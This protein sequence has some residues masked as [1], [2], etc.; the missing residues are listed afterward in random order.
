MAPESKYILGVDGGATKTTAIIA[1]LKGNVLSEYMTGSSNC[2][3]IGLGKSIK[4]I[5][6]AV[7]GALRKLD[8]IDHYRIVSSCFGM[9]GNDTGKDMEIYREIILNE[10]LAP[11]L[12]VSGV[13]LCNDTRIGLAAGS[14]NKNRIMVIAGTGA[15]CYG[16]NE[17]GREASSDGW[18]Y[19]LG[20][21]GS[22]Y[23]IAIKALRAVMKA[24]DGRGE[25]TKLSTMVLK[26]L[27]L[28]SEPD[29]VEWAYGKKTG[30]EDISSIAKVVCDA[31]E[32]GDKLSIR[33]LKEA[34]EEVLLS[35]SA[36][37]NKLA[38]ADKSF[39]LVLVGGL[40]KCREYFK[41][42]FVRALKDKYKKIIIREPVL[43]PVEGAVKMALE[44]YKN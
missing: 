31:A 25:K 1:D 29:L 34:S 44:N 15:N 22:G 6:A 11:I 42:I 8:N 7:F 35:V 12:D 40:F 17:S 19:I 9:A 3:S 24:Y 41:D 23:N 2:K 38:I 32:I 4:N 39:D 43:K 30:K 5:N 10:K 13:I 18:D 20:D 16:I 28:S 37:V 21:E 33:I 27:C 26:H 36:V 14:D